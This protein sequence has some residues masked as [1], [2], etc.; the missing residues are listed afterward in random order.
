MQIYEKWAKLQV[1]I[2][3]KVF[4]W[5][6]KLT[7]EIASSE[8]LFFNRIEK[9]QLFFDDIL[10]VSKGSEQQH[11]GYAFDCLKLLDLAYI[12]INLPKTLFL[13][14]VYCLHFCLV[15]FCPSKLKVYNSDPQSV[16]NAETVFFKSWFDFMIDLFQI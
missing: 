9:H 5:N 4:L 6:Q 8:G 11:L 15:V 16:R 13:K 14:N 3:L 10:I 12:L 1:L 2:D 7:C